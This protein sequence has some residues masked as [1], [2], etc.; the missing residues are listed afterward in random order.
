MFD[1]FFG[2]LGE[3]RGD[4]NIEISRCFSSHQGLSLNPS[5]SLIS[6]LLLSLFSSDYLQ[7]RTD[8]YRQTIFC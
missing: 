7:V 8:L 4:K 1:I 5:L 6:V 2:S 3:I